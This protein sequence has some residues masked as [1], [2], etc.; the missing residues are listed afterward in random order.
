M[1]DKTR[2]ADAFMALAKE[3]A[4]DQG[5]LF[6]LVQDRLREAYAEDGQTQTGEHSRKWFKLFAVMV[7][8][9]LSGN[10]IGIPDGYEF[11][12]QPKVTAEEYLNDFEAAKRKQLIK[13]KARATA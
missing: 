13:Q 11:F 10:G 3:Q 12:W 5:P 9:N 1:A 2:W 7:C 6:K 4:Y 8:M